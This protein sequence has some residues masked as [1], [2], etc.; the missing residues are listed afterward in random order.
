MKMKNGK[1]PTTNIQQPTSNF[2]A[3]L[4]GSLDIGCW[5]LDVGCSFSSL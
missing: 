1:H 3:L 4:G 5:M 2:G